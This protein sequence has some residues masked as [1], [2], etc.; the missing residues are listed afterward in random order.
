MNEAWMI[1]LLALGAHSSTAASLP[2]KKPVVLAKKQ[3]IKS[4]SSVKETAHVSN[5]DASAMTSIALHPEYHD[6]NRRVRL[7]LKKLPKQMNQMEI[8]SDGTAERLLGCSFPKTKEGGRWK[9]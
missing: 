5:I 8:Q 7:Y 6:A 2:E 4:I 9:C 1:W 3:D